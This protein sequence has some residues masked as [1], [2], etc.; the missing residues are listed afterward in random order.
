MGRGASGDLAEGRDPE[1]DHA[2]PAGPFV[3]FGELALGGGEADAQAL[4]FAEPALLL[5][6]GGS[7]VFFAGAQGPAAGDKS[8]VSVDCLLRVDRVIS[9]GG[10][11]VLVPEDKLGDMRWHPVQD[12]LGSKDSPEVV[13]GVIGGF[14]SAWHADVLQC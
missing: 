14:L 2:G 7:A 6:F 5:G 3:E 13:E 9:H 10:I 11:D 12:G 8:P 4:G 1:V